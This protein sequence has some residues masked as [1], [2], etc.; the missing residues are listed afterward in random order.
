MKYRYTDIR[1]LFWLTTRG[2]GQAIPHRISNTLVY[3]PEELKLNGKSYISPTFEQFLAS[4]DSTNDHEGVEKNFVDK[5]MCLRELATPYVHHMEDKS[6]TD[7]IWD[8]N[9]SAGK[10]FWEVI[11]SG[12]LY[13]RT[14][15][16]LSRRL[17]TCRMRRKL[18]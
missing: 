14:I 12:A 6:L 5:W 4:L 1:G 2:I 16:C 11:E 3:E 13:T 9:D 18:S 8:D 15:L 10:T 17:Q 7:L